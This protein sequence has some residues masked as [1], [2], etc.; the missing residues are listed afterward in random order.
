MLSLSN[1][2]LRFNLAGRGFNFCSSSC[3]C[4]RRFEEL[5]AEH[6]IGIGSAGLICCFE[7]RSEDRSVSRGASIPPGTG[8]ETGMIGFFFT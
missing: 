3:S 7:L 2:L 4:L 1:D 8:R 6:G 5:R